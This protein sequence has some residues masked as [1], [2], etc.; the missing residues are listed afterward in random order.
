M[1]ITSSLKLVK[2]PLHF[3]AAAAAV[4]YFPD[5]NNFGNSH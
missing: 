3:F 4:N 2:S 1:D 5:V